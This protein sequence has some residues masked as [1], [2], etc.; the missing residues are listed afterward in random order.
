[1]KP[2]V[3]KAKKRKTHSILLGRSDLLNSKSIVEQS[4]AREVLANVLLHQLD[5]EIRVVDALDLVTN[6]AD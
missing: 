2:G 5:T 6:T 1:M 4:V 3:T